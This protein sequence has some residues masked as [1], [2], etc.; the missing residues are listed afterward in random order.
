MRFLEFL[1]LFYKI[2]ITNN[3]F[4]KI[5]NLNL[6]CRLMGLRSN[7]VSY[8]TTKLSLI[9]NGYYFLVR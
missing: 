1:I 7:R 9:Y 8:P 6:W 2:E 3:Y 4:F 5:L